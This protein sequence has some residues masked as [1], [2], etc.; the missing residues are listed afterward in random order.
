MTIAPVYRFRH[1]VQPKGAWQALSLEQQMGPGWTFSDLAFYACNAAD[2]DTVPVYRFLHSQQP[3]GAWHTVSTSKDAGPGWTPDGEAFYAYASEQPGTVPVYRF[4]HDDQPEGAWQAFGTQT[5]LGPGWTMSDVAFY[6]YPV[7]VSHI[8]EI[9]IDTHSFTLTATPLPGTQRVLDSDYANFDGTF[10]SV[11]P[12]YSFSHD[13]Q[14]NGAWQAV[15]TQTDMGAGWTRNGILFYAFNTPTAAAVPV[16]RFT[17]SVYPKG[18]WQ[19]VSTSPNIGSGWDQVEVAF[20]AFDAPRAGCRPVTRY[21]HMDQPEGAWQAV[22]IDPLGPGWDPSGVAF[23]AVPTGGG[24]LLQQW[25]SLD[26]VDRASN[27]YTFSKRRTVLHAP[28]M[29]IQFV[30]EKQGPAEVYRLDFETLDQ[31]LQDP[32]RKAPWRFSTADGQ[33]TVVEQAAYAALV[34]SFGGTQAAAPP[35]VETTETPE[36]LQRRLSQATRPA[37]TPAGI[38]DLV[39]ETARDEILA[40][41]NVR[42][43]FGKS[44]TFIDEAFLK[45]TLILDNV[46]SEVAPPYNGNSLASALSAIGILTGILGVIS[47]PLKAES[48]V[49]IGMVNL[50]VSNLVSQIPVT[51]PVTVDKSWSDLSRVL[52]DR[53][54]QALDGNGRALHIVLSDYGLLQVIDS[55]IKSG[56]LSWPDD[57]S[58]ARAAAAVSYER[59]LWKTVLPLHYKIFVAGPA[60]KY[61]VKC[62]P[63]Y[64]DGVNHWLGHKREGDFA[65]LGRQS[66]P[67]AKRL[68]TL[69]GLGIRF[70]DLVDGTNNWNL[71]TET[72]AGVTISQLAP[73]RTDDW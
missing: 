7:A 13:D 8:L 21:M 47:L 52:M 49:V 30:A 39:V 12:V 59:E 31:V 54:S 20:Y 22:S 15:S 1:V 37:N 4:T 40:A 5:D 55:A 41:A 44:R 42:A 62:E 46:H 6:A 33:A 32:G 57:D 73:N 3:E 35:W 63:P 36:S 23:Y 9:P 68:F 71:E 64:G 19:A 61:H 18:A 70:Q 69:N 45:N 43:L 67:L 56:D 14:P 28:D 53:F 27:T 10:A 34:T 26:G 48:Q 72:W 38:W 51:D 58:Q 16:Y 11:V 60:F 2:A 25:L 17:H 24:A 66:T 65:E 29:S 50:A